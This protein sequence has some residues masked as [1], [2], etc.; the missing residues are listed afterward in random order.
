M[1]RALKERLAARSLQE[2]CSELAEVLPLNRMLHSR[3]VKRRRDARPRPP[4]PN[5]KPQAAE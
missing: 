1:N 2:Q 4:T 3:D 5:P